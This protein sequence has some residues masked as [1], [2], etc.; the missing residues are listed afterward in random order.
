MLCTIHLESNRVYP[1]NNCINNATN[2]INPANYYPQQQPSKPVNYPM[3]QAPP[4]V[5]FPTSSNLTPSETPTVVAPM[6]PSRPHNVIMTAAPS[7][8]PVPPGGVITINNNNRQQFFGPN[9]QNTFQMYGTQQI[10]PPGRLLSTKQVTI[11][12]YSNIAV[13]AA[14][15]SAPSS[16]TNNLPM[17]IVSTGTTATGLNPN[18]TLPNTTV[19]GPN[20]ISSFTVKETHAVKR[21]R[22]SLPS[23]LTHAQPT[24]G[25]WLNKRY[26]VN[27]YILLDILGEGSYAEVRLCK[28]RTSDNLY[29]MKII[30]KDMLSKRKSANNSETFFDDIRREIAIMKK[31]LHPNVLRLFEVLDDPKVSERSK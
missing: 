6:T 8:G 26:I 14:S 1:T 30:S 5:S 16:T 27:N 3:S 24:M 25:D 23:T 17:L 11:P 18:I 20:H 19:S 28:E 22:I 21:N 12:I 4:T 29:A 2:T 9:S 15:L 13:T 31:L 10:N 7:S